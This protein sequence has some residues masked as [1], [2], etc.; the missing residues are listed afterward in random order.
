M[1]TAEGSGRLLPAALAGGALL[2]CLLARPAPAGP[3]EAAAT[4]E[5]RLTVAVKGA[6]SLRGEGRS[7]S[8]EFV[9]RAVF[10]GRLLPDGD[11]FLLVH[12]RSEALEWGLRETGGREGEPAGPA[13]AG[14]PPPALRLNYV[15]REK[16][17]IE[18]DFEFE[19]VTVPLR[20]LGL[21]IPLELPRSAR[22]AGTKP[23]YDDL[24]LS[25][26]NRIVLPA[27][28]LERRRPERTFAW[29]WRRHER[30]QDGGRVFLETQD[31]SVE[32]VVA[33]ARR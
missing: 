32:A 5:V 28:D 31:H 11:D 7:V 13:I 21:E 22:P 3:G 14:P 16:K 19:G 23:G 1:R 10:E 2:A 8:G 24:V 17:L 25:G 30:R 18:I 15:L 33:L 4:W 12:G 26:S 6:Y 9:C 20:P 27:S 29:S